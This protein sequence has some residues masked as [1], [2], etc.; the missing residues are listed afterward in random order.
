[1]IVE[2]RK[3]FRVDDRLV[4]SW[5]PFNNEALAVDDLKEVMLLSVNREINDLISSLSSSSPEVA[6][7]LTH[8]NHKVELMNDRGRDS[9]YGPSL[10]RLNLSRAGIAFEWRGVIPVGSPIRLSLTFPPNNAKLTLAAEVLACEPMEE[11]GS[12]GYNKIRCRFIPTQEDKL[13]AVS[14]YIDYTQKMG[15]AKNRLRAPVGSEAEGSSGSS[16]FSAADLTKLTD[17]R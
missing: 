13:E 4:I 17:Y 9:L 11:A 14:N 10:A 5:R 16:K 7:V 3:Y 8:I 6:Q 15:N 2:H 1:M 12:D